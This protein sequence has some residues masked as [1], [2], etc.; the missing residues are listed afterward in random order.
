MK[1]KAKTIV[2]WVIIG[3][4]IFIIIFIVSIQIYRSVLKSDWYHEQ[5]TK[6]SFSQITQ[7]LNENINNIKIDHAGE[8]QFI[9]DIPMDLFDDL[10]ATDYQRIEDIEELREI[11][12]QDCVTVFFEEGSP[13]SFFI[14][15]NEEIYWGTDLKVECP[16]LLHWY[17]QRITKT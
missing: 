9:H 7:K 10:H 14:T 3:L 11:W 16:S 13:T 15:E 4:F 6:K 17:K 2:E 5:Q 8:I 12:S 1:L